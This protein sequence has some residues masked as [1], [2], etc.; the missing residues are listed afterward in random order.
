VYKGSAGGVH[1]PA[2]IRT[3]VADS[4][5]TGYWLVGTDGSV[6]AFAATNRGSMRGV[7]LNRPIAG[8]VS[9]GV[10]YLMVGSDGGIFNFS[11]QPYFGSLGGNPPASPIVSVAVYG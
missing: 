10:G 7:P 3:L 1:V 9:F 8:M 4:D 2:P 5:G 6:Y 11:N